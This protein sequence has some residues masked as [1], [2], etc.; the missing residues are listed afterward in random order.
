[1][2]RIQAIGARKSGVGKTTVVLGQADALVQCGRRVLVID[3]D[4]QSDATSV[5][6]RRMC[7]AFGSTTCATPARLSC[8]PKAC[9][10]ARSWRS[11]ATPTW[12]SLP[13]STSTSHRRPFGTPQTR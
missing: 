11:L 4:P 10:C 13:T 8:W 2:P 9:R 6:G 3:L 7:A 1:M 12:R 5:L